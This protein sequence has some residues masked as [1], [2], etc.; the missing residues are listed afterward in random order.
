MIETDAPFL[1]PQS[2]RGKRNESAF[3]PVLAGVLAE[4]RGIS[5]QEV[6]E[7]SS[8]NARQFFGLS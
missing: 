2:L 7:L 4:A 3:L 8:E 6:A 5:V 1:P